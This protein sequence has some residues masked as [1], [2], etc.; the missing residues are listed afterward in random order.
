MAI[1]INVKYIAGVYCVECWVKIN[2]VW[3]MCD[4]ILVILEL[5]RCVAW[6]VKNSIQVPHV[7][8]GIF[9]FTQPSIYPYMHVS[10]KLGTSKILLVWASYTE[11]SHVWRKP[12]EIT[13]FKTCMHMVHMGWWWIFFVFFPTTKQANLRCILEKDNFFIK[14]IDR[15][16]S[17]EFLFKASFRRWKFCPPARTLSVK[18][19]NSFVFHSS[20]DQLL[21]F[22]GLLLKLAE[23]ESCN[24]KRLVPLCRYFS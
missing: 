19:Y 13:N 8:L 1:V 17:L 4:K 16:T 15:K 24:I 10:Q 12:W 21:N 2:I 18:K 11:C 9:T 6:E 20:R 5:L 3:F 14:L 22:W 7:W 23:P